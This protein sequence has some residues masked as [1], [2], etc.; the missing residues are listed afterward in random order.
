[1]YL[2]SNCLI[3]V[4]VLQ[5]VETP[6]RSCLTYFFHKRCQKQNVD[7]NSVDM[8]AIKP[9]IEDAMRSAGISQRFFVKRCDLNWLLIT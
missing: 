9:A 6:F 5:F 1:M 7:I 3:G 8:I 4:H 2:K